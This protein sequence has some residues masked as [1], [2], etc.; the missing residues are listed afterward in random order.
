MAQINPSTTTNTS[1]TPECSQRKNVPDKAVTTNITVNK[2]NSPKDT[3]VIL[4]LDFSIVE[5]LNRIWVSISLFEL[6]KIAQF[7]NEIVNALPGRMP[8]IHQ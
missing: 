6:A 4:E 1:D 3:D 8:K 2:K 5:D 7:Q